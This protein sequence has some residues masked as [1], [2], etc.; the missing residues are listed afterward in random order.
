MAEKQYF[1][2]LGFCLDLDTTNC[3][4]QFDKCVKRFFAISFN[5]HSARGLD[6]HPTV[7]T[8]SRATSG[9][10]RCSTLRPVVLRSAGLVPSL[11]MRTCTAARG[12]KLHCASQHPLQPPV[13]SFA[14]LTRRTLARGDGDAGRRTPMISYR[15]CAA[16]PTFTNLCGF[17]CE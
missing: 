8:C 16:T 3:F 9:A 13:D 6:G 15:P 1:H 12:S 10:S 11:R 17:A 5:P 7:S 14:R 4:P 2:T